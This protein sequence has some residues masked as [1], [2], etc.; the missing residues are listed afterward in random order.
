MFDRNLNNIS[1]CVSGM[2]IITFSNWTF[3]KEQKNGS[4]EGDTVMHVGGHEGQERRLV[5]SMDDAERRA[6]S[7]KGNQFDRSGRLFLSISPWRHIE[8]LL[9]PFK[10]LF[11]IIVLVVRRQG[12]DDLLSDIW[13][14]CP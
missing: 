13:P 5:L 4:A 2:L 3:W 10:C 7:Q 1:V 12:V 8:S 9:N 11:L 14:A 6:V